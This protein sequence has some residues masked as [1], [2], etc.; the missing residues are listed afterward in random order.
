M[1]TFLKRDKNLKVKLEC[2][3]RA[4]SLTVEVFAGILAYQYMFC[5][6]KEQLKF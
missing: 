4:V 6:R 3:T 2:L 5:F 1:Y